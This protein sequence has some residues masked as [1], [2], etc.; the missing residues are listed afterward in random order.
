M[1][2]LVLSGGLFEISGQ[3][4][5]EIVSWIDPSRWGFASAAATTDLLKYFFFKDP[6]WEHT[7]WNWWRGVLV[8]LLQTALLGVAARFALRRYEPGRG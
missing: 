7:A 4:T 3:K 2:Q 1:A 5:L 8:L 6:I